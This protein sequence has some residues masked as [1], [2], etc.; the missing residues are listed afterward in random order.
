MVQSNYTS[1]ANIAITRTG[2]ATPQLAFLAMIAWIAC[3]TCHFLS[4]SRAPFREL[5]WLPFWSAG[6]R[7]RCNHRGPCGPV[8]KLETAEESYIYGFPMMAGY[9]RYGNDSPENGPLWD[10]AILVLCF[11]P[12]SHAKSRV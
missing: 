1:I 4:S 11:N 6:L 2:K 8:R 9:K 7:P 12:T 3:I 5:A 10:S